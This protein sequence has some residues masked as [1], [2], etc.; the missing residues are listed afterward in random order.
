MGKRIKSEWNIF[1]ESSDNIIYEYYY[2]KLYW[3][4]FIVE[5]IILV[6]INQDSV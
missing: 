5:K 1:Y 2:L 6:A 4:N 3:T